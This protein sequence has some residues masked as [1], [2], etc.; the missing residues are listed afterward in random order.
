MSLIEGT[1]CVAPEIIGADGE[2]T[3]TTHH[4]KRRAYAEPL[5]ESTTR[6]VGRYDTSCQIFTKENVVG[7]NGHPRTWFAIRSA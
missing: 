7:S 5:S 3:A 6:I 4:A 2:I 1:M